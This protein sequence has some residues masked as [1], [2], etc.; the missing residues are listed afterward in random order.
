[1]FTFL[2]LFLVSNILP[3][4]PALTPGQDL[5]SPPVLQFCRRKKKEKKK[6]M[7]FFLV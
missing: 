4:V 7:T 6:S 1:M 3:L 2:P 5:F